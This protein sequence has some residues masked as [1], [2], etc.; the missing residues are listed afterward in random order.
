MNFIT[1]QASGGWLKRFKDRHGIRQLQL[2]GEKASA[3]EEAAKHVTFSLANVITEGN[4]KLENIYNADESGLNH[5]A[6]PKRTLVLGEEKVAV[7]GKVSKERITIMCCANATGSHKIKILAIGKSKQPRCFPKNG[8]LPVHYDYSKK[9]WMTTAIFVKWYDTIFIPEVK[10]HQKKINSFG[11]VLLL[12][13]NAPTHP[14]AENLD[15]E[16]GAFKVQFLP[17]NVTSVIQPMDQNVIASLKVRYRKHLRDQIVRDDTNDLHVSEFIKKFQL[18]DA[19]Y[20]L[21]KSWS[22]VTQKSL[23]AAW[24]PILEQTDPEW[25][26]EEGPAIGD[27]EP[28][29]AGME[30]QYDRETLDWFKMDE[31]DPG[32]DIQNEQDIEEA[33]FGLA[34]ENGGAVSEDDDI[35]DEEGE[36]TEPERSVRTEEAVRVGEKFLE[37]MEQGDNFDSQDLIAMQRFIGIA[38]KDLFNRKQTTISMYFQPS[39]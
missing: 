39:T 22:E 34:N 20:L 1:F 17:P 8:K 3:D 38:K 37:Y 7:G 27:G 28:A 26:F 31:N 18:K 10:A 32:F 36:A 13:D 21:E 12:L 25:L 33:I 30:E 15:R 11:D 9:A 35:I 2:T 24:R 29:A 23:A 14:N 6:M 5:R 4:Y 19:L 16:D